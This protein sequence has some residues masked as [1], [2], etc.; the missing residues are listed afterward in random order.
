MYIPEW[1]ERREREERRQTIRLVAIILFCAT[2]LGGVWYDVSQ[3]K[4]TE[5]STT[6]VDREKIVNVDEDSG[7]WETT[8]LINGM[9]TTHADYLFIKTGDEVVVEETRGGITGFLYVRKIRRSK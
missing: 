5:Y 4:Y 6:V 1:R 3:Q 9:E 8:Y 2:L 7:M